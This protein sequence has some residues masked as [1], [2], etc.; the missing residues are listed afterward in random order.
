MIDSRR[1]VFDR[2]T[3][4]HKDHPGLW[5]DK[6]LPEQLR[7]DESPPAD[8]DTPQMAHF[9]S[10]AGIEEPSFYQRSFDRW[11]RVLQQLDARMEKGE[12]LG[13]MVV[14]LGADSVLENA[15]SLHHTYGLPFIPGSALKGLASSY[16]HLRLEN[17]A[18]NKGGE[19]HRILFGDT[20]SAGYVT[21]FDALYIPKSAKQGFLWP[22]VITVHHRDYYQKEGVAPADWDSPTIIPFISATGKYLIALAGPEAWVGKAFEIL[23]LALLEFGV[24]AKTSSGYG[25]VKLPGVSLPAPPEE[26]SEE[27]TTS[28]KSMGLEEGETYALAKVRLKKKPWPQGRKRGEVHAVRDWGAYINPL[29]GGGQVKLQKADLRNPDDVL[30]QGQILEYRQDGRGKRARALDAV[31]LLHSQPELKEMGFQ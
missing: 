30:K 11:Q 22:D 6:F 27:K 12:V 17:A 5:L 13:R 31:I 3:F 21:F 14:G 25:R 26:K 15:I 4:G 23:G 24:G 28:R 20:T 8:K 7:R 16:A 29:D 1:S 2:M 10:A 9:K 18:W 19:A